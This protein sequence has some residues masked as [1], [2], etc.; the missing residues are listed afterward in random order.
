MNTSNY[1]VEKS[2]DGRTWTSIATIVAAGQS[3]TQQ[4][5]TY[6]DNAGGVNSLYRIVEVESDGRKTISSIVRSNCGGR[7]AVSVYPN[8]VIDRAMVVISLENKTKLKL[9]LVDSKGA[10]VQVKEIELPAGTSQFPLNMTGYARG[11]YTLQLQWD[12]EHKTVQ[13]IRK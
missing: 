8:P 5:Y 3:T 11:N 13:L 1:L 7:Q 2:S 9:S 6:T 10:T 12:N 4:S